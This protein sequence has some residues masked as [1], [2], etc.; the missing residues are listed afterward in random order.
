[1]THAQVAHVAERHR[2]AG[3]V[4]G[5]HSMTSSARASR[6]GGMSRPIFYSGQSWPCQNQRHDGLLALVCRLNQQ[7]A[8]GGI[9]PRLHSDNVYSSGMAFAGSQSTNNG[10][11]V[12]WRC[13]RNGDNL[14]RG[15]ESDASQRFC[16]L[17]WLDWPAP[18]PSRSHGRRRQKW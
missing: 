11:D 16:D 14:Y 2:R 17:L 4:L 1:V 12:R 6:D 5:F 15:G 3:G 8:M 13:S 18:W 10:I 7:V 9:A